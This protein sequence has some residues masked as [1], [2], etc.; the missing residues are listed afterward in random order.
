MISSSKARRIVAALAVL[1]VLAPACS[2]APAGKPARKAA[3]KVFV[4]GFDGMDPTLSKKYMDEGKLPNLKKLADAG[5][6]RKLETTQPSESPV[7][8][9][10]FATGVNPGKHNIYD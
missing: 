6:F 2:K 1:A 8:W 3:R 4:I 9:S 7:A 10:S 5:T